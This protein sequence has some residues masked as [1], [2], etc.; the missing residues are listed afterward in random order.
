MVPIFWM[1][2]EETSTPIKAASAREA[3]AE[4]EET[5][6]AETL[7]P[8]PIFNRVTEA[9]G[10]RAAEFGMQKSGVPG[11]PWARLSRAQDRW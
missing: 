3:P 10:F 11:R 4:R 7:S 9:P 5:T 1:V 6:A 2:I 8:S